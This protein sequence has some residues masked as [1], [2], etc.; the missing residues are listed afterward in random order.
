MAGRLTPRPLG[1]P[2][3]G[4]IDQ[5]N[6]AHL[7]STAGAVKRARGVRYAGAGKLVTVGGT[8][9]L[10]T[11]QDD[12]GS[13]VTVT[14]VLAV[15]PFT[16]RT[17]AVAH[18]TN[19]NKVYL[20]VLPAT[21]DGWYNAAGVLQATLLPEPVG[22]LWTSVT[23]APDVTIAELLGVA[24]I[25]HTEG[26]S[27]T[28]LGFPTKTFALP[29][30]IATLTSDLDGAGGAEDLYALG[31]IA[32]QQHLWIWGVGSGTL[33]VNHYRPELARYSNP[34]SATFS[35]ADSIT[36]GN[37]VR[38]E[39]E[40]IVGAAVAGDSLFLGSPFGLTRITGFGRT[41]WFKKKLDNSFGFPGPKCMCVRVDTLY[42]FSSRG[43]MRC[44]EL[45]QP[46]PLWAGV[47]AAVAT[48][49]NPQ[50]VV[51]A[52]DAKN[53]TVIFT[54]DA[55]S[56]VRTVMRFDC[57]REV[58]L[59]PDD[60]Q[61]LAIRAADQVDPITASSV[62]GVAGPTAAPT[63]PVTSSVGASV[64]TCS[65]TNGD[66]TAFTA[67][68]YRRQG[69]VD[70][71]LFGYAEAGVATL[72]LT[73]LTA[74][75]GYEWRVAHY[76]NGQYS[77]YLGPSAGT[78]FTST[79]SSTGA[80]ALLPPSGLSLTRVDSGPGYASL[81][82]NWT[83]SG[84]SDVSTQVEAQGPNDTEFGGVGE[85]PV[86]SASLEWNVSESGLYTVRA[87]HKKGGYTDSAFTAEATLTVTIDEIDIL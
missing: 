60:D 3:R 54:Y 64:A 42:Y 43:P 31:T 38:S 25:A 21:M 75:A 80:T 15:K 17:L 63:A 73:G 77:S 9:V 8:R 30:T 1:P 59:G 87:C 20:Y 26:A 68:E 10:L 23:T 39:R 13:P 44:T 22:V 86:P 28:V 85:V 82:A 76:K 46:E 65:W 24:Y 11:L 6:A 2:T 52:Y 27:S 29:A 83:N 45:G 62:S 57:A 35:S 40:K 49:I 16:D 71:T 72:Q 67:L 48:V 53:D 78:Q 18:S 4:V 56:G 33:A 14:S 84:E 19:T 79:S 81:R 55:G 61:G 74:A 69:A 47:D 66:A 34:S 50:K 32:F 51:A 41:S 36:L 37:R 58:W 5:A 70:W 7:A 12:Q